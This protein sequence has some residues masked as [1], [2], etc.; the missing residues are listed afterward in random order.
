[1][2]TTTERNQGR[3]DAG[4]ASTTPAATA[5]VQAPP[6]FRRRPLVILAGVAM[7]CL[8]AVL[9]LWAWTAGTT[10]TEVVAV[11]ASVQRGAVIGA[12]DLM[13]VRVGLDPS[14]RTVSASGLAALVGKRAAVDLSAGSLLTP[15][16][17][18]SAVVPGQG[19][20]LVGVALTAGQ[21]PSAPLVNGDAVRIVSTPAKGA[22]ASGSPRVLA[23]TVASVT[24]VGDA[25]TGGVHFVVDLL[26]PAAAA[27]DL[28]AEANSGNVALVLDSR[29]R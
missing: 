7:V 14:L 15:D 8:G 28:A 1:M 18:T 17:V 13:R 2:T 9:G 24:T 11:R 5:T 4:A 22:D 16:A 6:R 27:A 29:E 3:R 12:S 10:Q 26:V 20:S 23:A 25:K 21:L 19:L